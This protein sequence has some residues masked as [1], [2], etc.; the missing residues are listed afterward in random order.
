MLS[1]DV[2][3]DAEIEPAEVDIS[4]DTGELR[5]LVGEPIDVGPGSSSSV[6]SVDAAV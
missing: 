5:E 1:S 3:T 6:G 2:R 4:S